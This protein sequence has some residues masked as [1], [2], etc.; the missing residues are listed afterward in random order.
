MILSC[1]GSIRLTLVLIEREGGLSN[2]C[3]NCGFDYPQ[4]LV[5]MFPGGGYLHSEDGV[6]WIWHLL[7]NLYSFLS[8]RSI[9][10][11]TLIH[12]LTSLIKI[13]YFVLQVILV[14]RS[15]FWI[16]KLLFFHKSVLLQAL[17]YVCFLIWRYGE[18]RVFTLFQVSLKHDPKR[19]KW[20]FNWKKLSC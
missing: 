10:L 6:V 14:S 20:T 18:R 11:A 9:I 19:D 7:V 13:D 1:Y 4:R 12:F 5:K 3:H 2:L 8:Q 15:R 17:C 16:H